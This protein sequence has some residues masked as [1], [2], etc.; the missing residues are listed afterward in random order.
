MPPD[1]HIQ[2]RTNQCFYASI[3]GISYMPSYTCPLTH[4]HAGANESVLC[5]IIFGIS[6]AL[7]GSCLGFHYAIGAYMG[8]LVLCPDDFKCEDPPAVEEGHAGIHTCVCV[9]VCVS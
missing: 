3:F 2:A 1:T 8:G 7:L 4:T 9:C 5:A 6:F